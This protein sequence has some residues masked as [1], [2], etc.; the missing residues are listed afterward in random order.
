MFYLIG[1][2]VNAEIIISPVIG[3]MAGFLY[4]KTE[5][6]ETTEYTLQCLIFI[7]CIS[8]VWEKQNG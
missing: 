2:F 1:E 4:S 5:L 6:E 7:V 3:I 8:V